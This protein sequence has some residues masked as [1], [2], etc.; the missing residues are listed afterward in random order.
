MSVAFS[1]SHPEKGPGPPAALFTTFLSM[2]PCQPASGITEVD[3]F[4]SKGPNQQQPPAFKEPWFAQ[5]HSSATITHAHTRRC[6][7]IV[8]TSLGEGE[9][10]EKTL[11]RM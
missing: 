4:G 1:T 6:T 10:E 7:A 11:L 2:L 5:W 9:G 8:N 3:E